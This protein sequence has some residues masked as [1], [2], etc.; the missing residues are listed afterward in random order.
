M[1]IVAVIDAMLAVVERHDLGVPVLED[2]RRVIEDTQ[3][4]AAP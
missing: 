3:A 4:A 2:L 1:A